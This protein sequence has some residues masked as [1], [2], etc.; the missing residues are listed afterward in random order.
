MYSCNKD[1]VSSFLSGKTRQVEENEPKLPMI[2]CESNNNDLRDTE[3]EYNGDCDYSEEGLSSSSRG[4]SDTISS[5]ERLR[6]KL[7]KERFYGSKYLGFPLVSSYSEKQFRVYSAVS[8]EIPLESHSNSSARTFDS[9]PRSS[10]ASKSQEMFCDTDYHDA[11]LPFRSKIID[12]SYSLHNNQYSQPSNI[13]QN[14]SLKQVESASFSD[15]KVAKQASNR[16]GKFLK[17]KIHRMTSNQYDSKDS[18]SF[19]DYKVYKQASNKCEKVLKSKI[20]RITSNEED[21]EDSK[22][23]IFNHTNSEVSLDSTQLECDNF[24]TTDAEFEPETEFDCGFENQDKYILKHCDSDTIVKAEEDC[25]EIQNKFDLN[26]TKKFPLQNIKTVKTELNDNALMPFNVSSALSTNHTAVLNDVLCQKQVLP[27]LSYPNNKVPLFTNLVKSRSITFET[28]SVWNSDLTE[29]VNFTSR[30]LDY[31]LD[32]VGMDQFVCEYDN[33]PSDNFMTFSPEMEYIRNNEFVPHYDCLKIKS[34]KLLK[35]GKEKYLSFP[36]ASIPIQITNENNFTKQ[37]LILEKK[38]LEEEISQMKRNSNSKTAIFESER[39][40]NDYKNAFDSNGCMAKNSV[41][42]YSSSEGFSEDEEFFKEFD[43]LS[44]CFDGISLEDLDNILATKPFSTDNGS[45]IM[46]SEATFPK[47]LF[48]EPVIFKYVDDDTQEEK[49]ILIYSKDFM[50][51][52]KENYDRTLTR[53]EV[54]SALIENSQLYDGP[55]IGIVTHVTEIRKYI[56]NK[57]TF[58]HSENVNSTSVD[59][60]K[61]EPSCCKCSCVK[62]SKK[63]QIPNYVGNKKRNGY[64]KK[65]ANTR[66][67][68]K[69]SIPKQKSSTQSKPFSKPF[70]HTF[71]KLNTTKQN[72]QQVDKDGSGVLHK[73]NDSLAEKCQNNKGDFFREGQKASYC[74]LQKVTTSSGDSDLQ[75]QNDGGA[76]DQI[77]TRSK[78]DAVPSSVRQL[79]ITIFKQRTFRK[80]SLQSEEET[81]CADTW[82]GTKSWRSTIRPTSSSAITNLTRKPWG[83]A[84][85]PSTPHSASA[86][87]DFT[88]NPWGNTVGSSAFQILR[89]ESSVVRRCSSFVRADSMAIAKYCPQTVQRLRIPVRKDPSAD[90]IASSEFKDYFCF[91]AKYGRTFRSGSA[92][93]K[94]NSNRWMQV[95]G[96]VWDAE[97][98]QCA[99]QCFAAIAR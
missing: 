1:T 24:Y 78:E 41:E 86:T 25:Q 20:H 65:T 81:S 52:I 19:S 48:H 93:C 28:S 90:E 23:F 17:S 79:D 63:V 43:N 54:L 14:I 45:P 70:S 83:S 33:M 57:S 74:I 36:K 75:H 47:L 92:I 89:A 21:S 95:T 71:K 56:K 13:F 53:E 87:A 31:L 38:N 5:I 18:K 60:G 99:E 30:S 32:E 3:E 72:P 96:V 34:E 44:D 98:Q 12:S 76:G 49:E 42:D 15:Y 8:Q 77:R 10:N 94:A 68:D 73:T 22:R 91:Y 67:H 9:Y 59:H 11:T 26:M 4:Q 35:T 2:I 66:S 39:N 27:M 97:S 16:D 62:K 84:I 50:A 55:S 46:R 61:Q 29:P 82:S 80:S 37:K 7:N 51:N 85:L 58:N 6:Q 40:A 64:G 69:C 88:R